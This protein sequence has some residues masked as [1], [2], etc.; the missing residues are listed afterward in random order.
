MKHMLRI[1]LIGVVLLT[2][3]LVGQ[4]WPQ[5]Q[6]PA[7]N[8]NPA[9]VGPPSAGSVGGRT[10]RDNL[11]EMNRLLARA[12]GLSHNVGEDGDLSPATL[13]EINDIVSQVTKLK[14]ETMDALPRL[15]G[16]SFRAFYD[17]FRGLDDLL[18]SAETSSTPGGGHGSGFALTMLQT[19]LESAKKAKEQV[20][21]MVPAS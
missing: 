19:F 10:I 2:G 4:H 5:S 21:G 18:G 1:T 13:S 15:Y 7:Q 16:Q 8:F 6:A 12:N 9:N 20:E 11:A 17:A 14:F 3:V